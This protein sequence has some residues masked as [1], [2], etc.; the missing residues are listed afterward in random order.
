MA[1]GKIPDP[2]TRRHWIQKE[3]DPAQAL[4][5][6]EAYL[7]EGR[8]MDALAF[9]AKAGADVI[10]RETFGS[11]L[12][13]GEEAL[14]L[15]GLEPSR[16]RRHA[17]TFQRHDE[18]GLLKLY[19]VWGDDQAYGLRVRQNLEDLETVLRDDMESR[20]DAGLIEDEDSDPLAAW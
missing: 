14:R 2:L 10:R 18:E 3:M 6:A 16:A 19:E 9:L 5:T 12:M 1:R 13:V 8:R 17:R 11:A 15:L 20:Q 4:A 7:A